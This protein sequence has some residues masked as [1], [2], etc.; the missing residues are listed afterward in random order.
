VV[1]L[2]CV[3]ALCYA[4]FSARVPKAGSAYIYRYL[5]REAQGCSPKKEVG[6]A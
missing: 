1:T 6:D 5:H 2:S 4:E 3:S